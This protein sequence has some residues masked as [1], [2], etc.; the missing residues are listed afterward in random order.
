MMMRS[1][2]LRAA[3]MYSVRVRGLCTVIVSVETLP[4]GHI[5]FS[6]L[7]LMCVVKECPELLFV[8]V[9]L[10]GVYTLAEGFPVAVMG[11]LRG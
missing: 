2:L 11:L 10:S 4:C 5:H 9:R 3:V 6:G 8:C 7:P 1:I